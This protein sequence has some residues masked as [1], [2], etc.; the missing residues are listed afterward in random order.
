VQKLQTQRS[1]CEKDT[2]ETSRGRY[3]GRRELGTER[4]R[5]RRVTEAK[6]RERS[7]GTSYHRA[8]PEANPQQTPGTPQINPTKQR[9]TTGDQPAN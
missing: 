4:L 3:L 6:R 5:L 2:A 9:R 1:I 7:E 8:P